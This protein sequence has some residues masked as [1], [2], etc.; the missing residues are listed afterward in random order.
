MIQKHQ[1]T[2]VSLRPIQ[3]LRPVHPPAHSPQ[4]VNP[5]Q[6]RQASDPSHP[7]KNSA[8]PESIQKALEAMNFETA[9]PVQEQAIPVALKGQDII[10][11][12]QTGTGKTAAFCIPTLTRLIAKPNKIALVLAPTREL[13]RQIQTVWGEL[14]RF[15]PGMKSTVLVGGMPMNPQIRALQQRPRLMI[16]TPGRLIDHLNRHTVSLAHLDILVLD[17]ADHMLDMGFAP[18]LAKI[19]RYVPQNRQTL[20]FSATWNP[21]IDGLSQKYLKNPVRISVAKTNQAAETVCQSMIS[22]TNKQKNE[23]LLDELNQRQGSILVF[24]RTKSRT[25]RV[26]KFLASYG[27]DVHRIHGGRTQGQ[28]NSAL[29]AFRSG[30]TRVLVATDIAARGIDITRIAHVI[31]YD[32]PQ[33]PQDYVHRIGRTGRAGVKGNAVSLVTP[34]ERG[35]WKAIEALLKKSGSNLPQSMQAKNP[36][37]LARV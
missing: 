26:T 23:A 28:R 19:V 31:N 34:E 12:A 4:K 36:A 32:L 37:H 6:A 7:F 16:A 20:L 35:Q 18:Q 14:I 30:Q 22:T 2:P 24:A 3:P 27:V 5:S 8:I 21:T 25:D 15:V 9:T 17:E 1:I 33:V 11:L 10:A 29:S 13:A